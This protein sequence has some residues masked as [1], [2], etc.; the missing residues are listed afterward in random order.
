MPKITSLRG[1][2]ERLDGK[3]MLRIPLAAGGSANGKFNIT[4]VDVDNAP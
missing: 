4:T 2:G 1:P 3:L